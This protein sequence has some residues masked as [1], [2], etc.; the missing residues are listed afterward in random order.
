MI[1]INDT[2]LVLAWDPNNQVYRDKAGH[3]WKM[4][5]HGSLFSNRHGGFFDSQQYEVISGKLVDKEGRELK[6]WVT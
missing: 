2:S 6:R 1:K 4:D 5:E 3:P